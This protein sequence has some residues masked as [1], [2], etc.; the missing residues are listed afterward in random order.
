MSGSRGRHTM[1]NCITIYL[2]LVVRIKELISDIKVERIKE[3]ILDI[4][5][6]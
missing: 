6:R 2:R 1:F 4:K 3:L 5:V